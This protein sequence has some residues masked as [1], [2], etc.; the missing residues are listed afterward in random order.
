VKR[1]TIF[2]VAIFLLCLGVSCNKNAANLITVPTNTLL[3]SLIPTASL[4]PVHLTATAAP[5]SAKDGP[6]STPTP[7]NT[8]EEIVADCPGKSLSPEEC[9]NVGKH[10][11]FAL[12]TLTNSDGT[13]NC[14]IDNSTSNI[15]FVFDGKANL[16]MDS[17]EGVVKKFSRSA[18]NSYSRSWLNSP[19]NF[20][21]WN[22]TLT[23]NEYGFEEEI[24]VFHAKDNA[25]LCKWHTIYT[26]TSAN[27][28]VLTATRA[29]YTMPW[30]GMQYSPDKWQVEKVENNPLIQGLLTHLTIPDCQVTV[31]AV[32]PTFTINWLSSN[33]GQGPSNQETFYWSN[34]QE[35][36]TNRLTLNLVT[37]ENRN[38]ERIVYYEVFDK[39]GFFGSDK[40]RLGYFLFSQG[41]NVET[42]RK[43]FSDV[44]LTLQ[45]AQWPTLPV[46]Q[47]T[48]TLKAMNL[49]TPYV[50]STLDRHDPVSVL[51]TYLYAW[52]QGDNATQ[53]SL[54]DQKSRQKIQEPVDSL[55]VVEIQPTRILHQSSTRHGYRVYVEITLNGKKDIPSFTY[56]LIW[57]A[58][59]DSWLITEYAVG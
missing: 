49:P 1:F 34:I 54:F 27:P 43:A 19:D 48:E 32:V 55:D 18:K 20:Y 52:K 59:H 56:T 21:L 7:F 35:T 6:S 37:S 28:I 33:R 25:L 51:N 45:I 39:T 3:P 11:Y 46:A 10:N 42:C 50:P 57:S 14:E 4:T 29:A 58:E 31:I 36:T 16:T 2:L 8:S 53:I 44:L 12:D 40:F 47:G 41:P 22:T 9:I 26:L 17:G 38:K 30:L 23:F 15:N 13:T 24:G 5:S